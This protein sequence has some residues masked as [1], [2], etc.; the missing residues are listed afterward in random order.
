MTARTIA[1]E[2]FPLWL[3]LVGIDRA[4]FD[5]RAK[6]FSGSFSMARWD[7][8]QASIAIHECLAIPDDDLTAQL[9]LARYL[10]SFAEEQSFTLSQMLAK[11]DQVQRTWDLARQLRGLLDREDLMLQRAGFAATLH[12]ALAHYG[13]QDRPDITEAL[14]DDALLAQ[15]RRD[16]YYGIDQLRMD[17]FLD[18]DTGT[19]PRPGYNTAIRRWWSL[20]DMLAAATHLPEGVSLNVVQPSLSHELFFSF[21]VRRG[22]KLYL[23]HDAPDREHPLQA[24]MSRR[25]ER[26]L[27]GR[28]AKFWFPYEMAGVAVSAAGRD[29]HV[30]TDRSKALDLPGRFKDRSSL[31]GYV[32]DLPPAE[33][34][35]SAMMFDRILSRFWGDE[36]L[37]ALALSCT[38]GQLHAEAVPLLAEAQQAGLPAVVDVRPH[39]TLPAL[40]HADVLGLHNAPE[41]AESLGDTDTLHDRQWLIDRYAAQVPETAFNLVAAGD[42]VAQ[43]AHDGQMDIV[44]DPDHHALKNDAFFGRSTALASLHMMEPTHFGTAPQLQADRQFVARHNLARSIGGLARQEYEARKDEVAQWLR[45]RYSAVRERLLG[46]VPHAQA[47]ALTVID[48]PA[49]QGPDSYD[50]VS[51]RPLN[52]KLDRSGEG[53]A[54]LS[55]ALGVVLP[56]RHTGGYMTDPLMGMAIL[57]GSSNR[58]RVCETTQGPPS[59]WAAFRPTNS[60]ELAWLLDCAIDDL[61]DVLRHRSGFSTATGNQIL[62]RID[63]M[64]WALND[65]WSKLDLGVQFPLSKR[66]LTQL[67]KTASIPTVDLTPLH[68]AG[69]RLFRPEASE[70]SE[71]IVTRR[72]R[73][74]R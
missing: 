17:Q 39:L 52:S 56:Y 64:L 3:D 42:Q 41:A 12:D 29:A 58:G 33:L 44:T 32:S 26:A 43:L 74:R 35:W 30:R 73:R 8:T 59:Y 48:W 28:M 38:A 21:V 23:L 25:P 57:P 37:P 68:G 34:L 36:P 51:P 54:G 20:D 53:R 18:G 71:P 46:L 72:S 1:D 2:A 60:V 15:L 10:E 67:V 27:A 22:A 4:H 45:Q 65:P 62:N 40:S 14:E 61:P 13:A 70:A 63:P 5:A 69:L 24:F 66:G 6:E 50:I 55:H 7:A 16:A 11:P 9:M 47:D 31:V 19:G 49:G